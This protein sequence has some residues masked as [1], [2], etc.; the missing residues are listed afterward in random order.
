MEIETPQISIRDIPIVQEF[1]NVFRENIPGMP[2]PREVEFCINLMPSATP[3]SKAP[4]RMAPTEHKEL[5]T[6][7]DEL[8]EKG[9]IWPSM[10]PWGAGALCEEKRWS[11]KTVH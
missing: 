8:L 9:H 4:Y 3:I 10:S 1:L 5:K 2:L 11:L 6:Q 7:L